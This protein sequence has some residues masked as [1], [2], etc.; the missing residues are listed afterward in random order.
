[1]LPELNGKLTGMAFRVPTPNVSGRRWWQAA[2]R[3]SGLTLAG[4]ECAGACACRPPCCLPQEGVNSCILPLPCT[5]H[6]AVVDLSA[7]LHKCASI[8]AIIAAPHTQPLATCCAH[9]YFCLVAVVDL[10]VNLNKGAS[11][12]DIM[13]ELKR[14]S[15]QELKGILG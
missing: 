11:Y 13:A 4:L 5:D 1:M 8:D 12:D 10:T 9:A 2:G 14:A 6:C 7:S 15:E 3:W